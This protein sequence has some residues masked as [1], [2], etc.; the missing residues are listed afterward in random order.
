[1][2]TASKLPSPQDLRQP[3]QD[4]A[5]PQGP[6]LPGTHPCSAF[7]LLEASPHHFWLEEVFIF[8]GNCRNE[9]F[10]LLSNLTKER[11]KETPTL[12]RRW[13]LLKR[14]QHIASPIPALTYTSEAGNPPLHCNHRSCAR[15]LLTLSESPWCP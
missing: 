7:C 11:N 4:T 1:M 15:F 13:G 5:L 6:L 14:P 2:R 3:V 12:A 8:Q 9:S 10:F